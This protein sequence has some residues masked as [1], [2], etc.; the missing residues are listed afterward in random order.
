M[1]RRLGKKPL[2]SEGPRIRTTSGGPMFVVLAT[3]LTS[4]SWDGDAKDTPADVGTID[5][6]AVFG[7]PP[8]IKAV[9][10]RLIIQ[11]ETVGVIGGLSRGALYGN[12]VMQYTQVANQE[13]AAMGLVPCDE[14]GDVYFYCSGELDNVYIGIYAYWI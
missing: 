5:L 4:T 13:I 12:I 6:S 2:E 14:N 10:V 3:P 8:G 1:Q 7:A 9:S 11:D